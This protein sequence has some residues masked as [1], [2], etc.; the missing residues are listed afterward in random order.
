MSEIIEA[1]LKKQTFA[2]VGASATTEKYGY[3]VWRMLREHGKTAYAVN[4]NASQIKGETVYP[5][6]SDLPVVPDVVV[7]VV[8]PAATETLPTQMVALGIVYLWMQP[9][10][11]SAKAVT[12]AEAAGIETIHDGTC[13]MMELRKC[14]RG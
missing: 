14:D 12:D 1:I 4:P 8:P 3:K 13:I 5:A 11:E 6:L 10:A 2:V 9:G 7:S